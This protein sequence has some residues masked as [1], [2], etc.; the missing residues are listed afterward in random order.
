MSEECV[1]CAIVS[2]SEPAERIYE[3]ETVVAIM[4]LHPATEG[5]VLVIPKRHSRDIWDVR[6]EDAERA[7]TA[8]VQVAGMIRRGLAPRGIS[9]VHASGPAAWQTVFHFHLHVIPRYEGDSL[10]PPWPLDQPQADRSSLREVAER[11]RWTGESGPLSPLD[12]SPQ[13]G[14]RTR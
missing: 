7:M 13:L 8:S 10:V 12:S 1:L 5:H 6:P 3:D 14:D 9:L 11:I 2:G 4:D